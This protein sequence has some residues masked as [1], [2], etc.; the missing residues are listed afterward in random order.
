MNVT[1]I[2]P[3]SASVV[4]ALRDLGLRNAGTPLLIASTPVRAAEPGRERPQDEE[5]AAEPGEPLLQIGLR[6]D[7]EGRA[8]RLRQVTGG[9]PDEPDDRDRPDPEHVQVHRERERGAR[10]PAPRADS[11]A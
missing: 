5:G 9:P 4:A 11:R 1:E 2:P 6:D 10:T 3:S 8:R 7:L